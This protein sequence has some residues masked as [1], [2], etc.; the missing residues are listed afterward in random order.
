M[1]VGL[2][3]SYAVLLIG[4]L[5]PIWSGAHASLAIPAAD[6]KRLRELRKAGKKPGV[7]Q[8]VDSD[9]E[10]E[11]ETT[12]R[13]TREDALWF[14]IVGSCVLL[15]LFLLFRFLDKRLLN[16]ILGAYLAVLAVA[17]L[18]RTLTKVARGAVGPKR[19]SKS[20]K[21]RLLLTRDKSEWLKVTLTSFGLGAFMLALGL[22]TAQIYTGHWVLV[23]IVA[24][25]F[26]YNAIS[27]IAL[28]S[29]ITG[30]ILL[31]GLF[32][33]DVWWVFGSKHVFGD[34]VMVEVATSFDGPIKIVFPRN[35]A[36]GKDFTLLGLGDI[37]LPGVFLAL[38]L[39]FDYH[40]AR[41]AQDAPLK[42]SARFAKPYFTACF[43]AYVLGLC[44]TM[45][46]MHFFRAAQPALLYLSPAC[47]LA[48]AVTAS[49]RGESKELWR[50]VEE[51]DGSSGEK[52]KKEEGGAKE[53][54]HATVAK[55]GAAVGAVRDALQSGS[56]AASSASD[57]SGSSTHLP[58]VTPR[59]RRRAQAQELDAR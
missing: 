35:L 37:V 42:P 16:R 33:Y 6:R 58:E 34:N 25:S 11:E 52:D 29:F 50:Y 22:A 21:W 59:L 14:P 48:V 41:S 20:S 17:G 4:A 55:D 38:A 40:R 26:A 43:A 49:M 8:E 7:E 15:G 36:A 3:R 1:S 18:T 28:D 45:T 57:P 44:T 56:S 47:I 54:E 12:E 30:S 9:D 24:L 39:R 31:A 13:L 2:Y 53:H 51:E 23:N 10:E 46:A 32:V 5:V 27:L 19:Y